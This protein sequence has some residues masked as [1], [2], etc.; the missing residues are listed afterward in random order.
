[1]KEAKIVPN[2]DIV[3]VT[4]GNKSSI[5]T[6]RTALAMGCD[7]GIHIPTEQRIDYMELQ[8][9]MIAQMFYQLIQKEQPDLILFGKQS[10]DSDCGHVGTYLGGLCNI[11]CISYASKITI[12]NPTND[13]L[14]ERETDTGTE[15]IQINQLPAI[16]TCDLRLNEPRYASLPNM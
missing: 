1:M 12:N 16:I 7:R 6:L 14:V 8:P 5:E 13:V 3:A 2:T 15:T 9:S 4:I 10:I 11:P